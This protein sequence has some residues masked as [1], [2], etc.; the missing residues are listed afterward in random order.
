MK[1][2]VLIK[3]HDITDCGAACLAV[4]AAWHKLYLPIARIR[5]Y[6]GTDQKGTN[7][8]GLVE[9]AEKLGFSA[10]GVRGSLEV[11]P[12]IPLPAI[13]HLVLENGLH[14]YVVL[15]HVSKRFI[16]I[17]DPAIGRLKK[18]RPAEFTREWTGVLVMLIPGERFVKMDSLMPPMARL[19]Q[20]I[21]PHSGVMVQTL[22]GALVFTV[23]GLAMSVYVQKIVDFVLVDGNIRLLNLMSMV[24]IGLLIMQLLIGF[25]KSI[26]V[27][28]TGQFIDA[29][30]ILGYYRHL[31]ELPQKF[32]DTMRVGEIM[33]R[34]NDAVKIRLFINDIA[35][36]LLVN[37]FMIV[38][39]L[40]LMFIYHWKLALLMLLIFPF[41][42]LLFFLSHSINK[43]WQLK[44]MQDSAEL[45]AGLVESLNNISTVRQLH[46]EKFIHSKTEG[47]FIRLLRTLYTISVKSLWLGSFTEFTTRAFT[48]LILWAGS[49]YVV[50]GAMS[51]G[52]LLSFYALIGY[53]TAP[54]VFLINANKMVQEAL[55][56]SA[57][58]YEIID[59]E[60]ET[61]HSALAQIPF[62]GE[63]FIEFNGVSFSYSNRS[64]LFEDFNLQIPIGTTVAITGESG[65]GKSTLMY[66]LQQL[67]PLN[68]GK[69]TISA[70]DIRMYP[71][72]QLRQ[73]IGI[74]P[75]Q[76][77]L[78]S[79][80]VAENIAIGDTEPDYERLIR[81]SISLDIHEMI[82]SLPL[83]YNTMI[84]ENGVNLSGGQSQRL[85]IARALYRNPKILVLDEPTSALDQQ[86][87]ATVLKSIRQ[88][89]S[90]Q[91]TVIFITHD[92]NVLPYC[93][94]VF[95]LRDGKIIESR[96][97]NT[98][99]Y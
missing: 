58:L 17:M 11:L 51:P 43:K 52:E 7:V 69:I 55:I 20:L 38:C 23:L 16:T 63:G 91:T 42:G 24:M 70:M 37:S 90:E 41:Y 30:L 62:S 88:Y 9:A 77:A 64:V 13:A 39:A 98:G 60:T 65:S 54:A 97:L 6:A 87:A 27:L 99:T 94:H 28:R 49:Y 80:T 76:N 18:M 36:S 78:F 85:A 84:G 73:L 12:K 92:A 2:G 29:R 35:V 8:L 26:L 15:M 83:G 79:G 32:F 1:K 61:Q 68:K 71:A 72:G 56:A 95:H 14:H 10:K 50:E 4:I 96:A 19:W 45:E 67:Y 31:L 53:F 82:S 66:L 75:Q 46:L 57:R 25:F 5:Q 21:R 3:Q 34:L 89:G 33:S 44:V 59:L 93:D 81:I 74:V 22:I 48:I 47:N 40:A 86:T